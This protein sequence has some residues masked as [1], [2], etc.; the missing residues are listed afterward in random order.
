MGILGLALKFFLYSCWAKFLWWVERSH[1]LTLI[2]STQRYTKINKQAQSG[3]KFI[4]LSPRLFKLYIHSIHDVAGFGSTG[5]R[6]W[7][8]VI[9]IFLVK[10][11]R[12]IWYFIFVGFKNKSKKNIEKISKIVECDSDNDIWK[13]E[14]S[15]DIQCFSIIF[16]ASYNWINNV[17]AH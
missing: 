10:S 17:E 2:H 16:C 5:Y 11:S 14:N 6:R 7:D 1:M 12:F 3:C 15:H 8:C 9:L 4:I 13:V